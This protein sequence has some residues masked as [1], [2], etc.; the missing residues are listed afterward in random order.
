[1]QCAEWT[2]VANAHGNNSTRLTSS[3]SKQANAAAEQQQGAA[4]RSSKEH[5]QQG[6]GFTR[7]SCFKLGS[8][9]ALP[10]HTLTN[11]SPTCSQLASRRQVREE[12]AATAIAHWLLLTAAQPDRSSERRRGVVLRMARMARSETRTHCASD[13]DLRLLM[14]HRWRNAE[15][16]SS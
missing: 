6:A 7:F 2:P 5:E 4:A 1:M 15:S 13:S 16:V 14:W 10:Q 9:A 8:P 11:S 12:S 3:I